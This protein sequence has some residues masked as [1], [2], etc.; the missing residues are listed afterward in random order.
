MITLDLKQD[1]FAI[2]SPR[3]PCSRVEPHSSACSSF[4][5]KAVLFDI[6]CDMELTRL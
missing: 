1:P 5:I 4:K 2:V 6:H 3:A